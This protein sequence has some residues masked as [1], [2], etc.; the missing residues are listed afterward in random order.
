MQDIKHSSP[1]PETLPMLNQL[2]RTMLAS[3][4]LMKRIRREKR[5][6]PQE[7]ASGQNEKH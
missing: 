7:S 1:S 3:I 4:A 5:R 2:E 6:S